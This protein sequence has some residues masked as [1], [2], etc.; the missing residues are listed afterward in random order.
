MP[1]DAIITDALARELQESVAG[2]RIDKIQQPAR[3]ILLLTIHAKS[4][5]PKLLI[6][7]GTSGA[8]VHITQESFENPSSP[9]M[10][11]MLL[12]KHLI[13]ARITRLYQPEHER[14]LIFE[15]ESVDALGE[16]AP[17][18]LIAE[19]MGRNSN[20][21]LVDGDGRIVDCLRR[22]S[23]EGPR[24]RQMQPGMFYVPPPK[25][26]KLDFLSQSAGE[27]SDVLSAALSEKPADKWLGEVFAGLSPLVCRE[28]SFLACGE[29][30]KPLSTFSQSERGALKSEL[31]SLRSRA[32]AGEYS[33]VM[34]GSDDAPLDFCFM[35]ITQYEGAADERVFPDFSALLDSFY[36]RRDREE[37]FR[38]K[39]QALQKSV[40]SAHER[41]LRKLAARREELSQAEDREKWRRRGELVTANLYKLK[42]GDSTLICE[43]WFAENA[44]LTEIA[45]DPLK[46]PSQN[47]AAFFKKYN[48]AKTAEAHLTELIE[49]GERERAYLASVLDE[50]SRATQERELAEIRRELTETG[51]IKAPKDPQK[52]KKKASGSNKPPEPLRFTAASGMTILVGRN[53]S[54][55]DY[56]TFRLAR[57]TDYWLHVQRLHG[58]HVVISCEGQEPD[59]QTIH[60]AASLAVY[61]SQARGSGRTAV[62]ITQIRNVKNPPGSMPGFVTYSDYRTVIAIGQII[63]NR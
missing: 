63:D 10:F 47:A 38:R 32:E 14:A 49:K 61:Y 28:L 6:S 1:L 9:P 15:L 18:R 21:I 41:A 20:I 27:L 46:S 31:L 40:K 25:Q 59:E 26:N 30:S 62:D 44:P 50:F 56:L 53:N 22:V 17:K 48:K 52:G 33:P 57:R 29:T 7:C 54:Q 51:F 3:D 37:A 34:L 60:E 36:T 12:R 58:S 11:C 24:A 4:G 23:G 39:A 45:L 55:N 16:S 35:P 5:N 43:D 42:K 19:L 8:R 2:A 13:G